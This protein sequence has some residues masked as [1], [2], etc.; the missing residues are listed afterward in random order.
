MVN[1]PA[2]TIRNGKVV[3]EYFDFD[4]TEALV[5]SQHRK[6]INA[7]HKAIFDKYGQRTLEVSS[8]GEVELGCNLSAFRLKLDGLNIENIY[9]SSKV[10]TNGG[11]YTDLLH[12]TPKESKE[13]SRHST[14]GELIGWEYNGR[15]WDKNPITVFYDYIY[16]CGV[17]QSYGK[18]L[19]LSGYDWFTDIFFIPNE[20]MNCQARALTIYKLLQQKDMFDILDDMDAWLQMQRET[21]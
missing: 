21:L 8:K 2:W 15:K 7:L 19:D 18:D 14:S 3:Q 20:S 16:L 11:P 6:N 17:L 4:W 12:V 10:Y 9:Q 1:R 13:D 5:L